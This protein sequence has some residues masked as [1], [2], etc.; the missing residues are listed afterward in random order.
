MTLQIGGVQK[1]INIFLYISGEARELIALCTGEFTTRPVLFLTFV[2]AFV[3]IYV[4]D[5]SCVGMYSVFFFFF[6]CISPV[7]PSCIATFNVSLYVLLDLYLFW[8][9]FSVAGLFLS[10]VT[11]YVSLFCFTSF[12]L[13]HVVCIY[14]ERLFLYPFN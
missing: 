11:F 13:H 8:V 4:L 12:S 2:L 9:T 3:L 7:S 14:L 10:S 1:F 6:S 5:R